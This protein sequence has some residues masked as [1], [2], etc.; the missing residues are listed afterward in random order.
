MS[1]LSCL[2]LCLKSSPENLEE[3]ILPSYNMKNNLEESSVAFIMTYKP[4]Y[5]LK[6]SS[7]LSFAST[8]TKF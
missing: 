8:E 7:D 1:A 3:N 2:F 6:V 4:A 5:K